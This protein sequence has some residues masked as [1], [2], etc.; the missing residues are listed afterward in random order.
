MIDK[1][2]I[3]I[4]VAKDYIFP[5]F[6]FGCNKEGVWLC[7]Y[8]QQKI[9]LTGVFCCPVC[10]KDTVEG[11]CCEGCKAKSFLDSH[12]ATTPYQEESLVG[13]LIAALK[14]QYAEDVKSVFEIIVKEF[15]EGQKGAFLP[16]DWIVPVP[17]HKKRFA[18]RGYNQAEIIAQI[19]T[20]L[21]DLPLHIILK[22]HKATKQ[23]AKLK[24][25]ERLLNLKDAFCLVDDVNVWDKNILLVDDVYT[26][27]STIGECAKV[28]KSAGASEVRGFSVAR[29]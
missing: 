9:D 4:K 25:E 12:I 18:E 20:E 19:L 28:L 29:G 21:L 8:C 26:T 16:Y 23:Q 11:I 14:Y 27:G 15:V 2:K 17:L 24:R 6:C 10:H 1:A 13:K 22:R 5:V 7:D 3:Y